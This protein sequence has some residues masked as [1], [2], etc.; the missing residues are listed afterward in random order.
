MEIPLPSVTHKPG[1]HLKLCEYPLVT[2]RQSSQTSQRSRLYYMF[3][4]NM[5]RLG[6]YANI[7]RLLSSPE[8]NG[9][10]GPVLPVSPIFRNQPPQYIKPESIIQPFSV[11][12]C[13]IVNAK[14]KLLC[15]CACSRKSLFCV[16]GLEYR[17]ALI[18]SVN[19]VYLDGFLP[20]MHFGI[21]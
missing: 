17:K 16:I 3:L 4:G 21:G 18:P 9:D 7:L 14:I 5:P 8:P 12:T 20:V 6:R 1:F 19:Q 13:G 15:Y 10:K 11:M 2:K